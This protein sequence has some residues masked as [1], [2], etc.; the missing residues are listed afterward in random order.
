MFFFGGR[1]GR[2]SSIPLTPSQKKLKT[3]MI[4]TFFKV[5]DFF[6]YPIFFVCNSTLSSFI[7]IYI[8]KDFAAGSI[9]ITFNI[10]DLYNI[11]ILKTC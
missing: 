11:L 7:P 8:V 1:G 3:A 4:Y 2:Q 6:F 5:Y 9:H 10:P